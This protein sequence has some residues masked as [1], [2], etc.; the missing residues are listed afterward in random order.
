MKSKAFN[1]VTEKM[2]QGNSLPKS[3]EPSSPKKKT[4]K[5]KA[6]QAPNKSKVPDKPPAAAA[7]IAKTQS[8]TSVLRRSTT[9][10][11]KGIV[12]GGGNTSRDNDT[13]ESVKNRGPSSTNR[14]SPAKL[15]SKIKQ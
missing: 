2:G 5:L 8:K 13:L 12:S 10:K 1:T 11:L 9:K 3:K 4:S 14:N 6:K 7:T 15:E